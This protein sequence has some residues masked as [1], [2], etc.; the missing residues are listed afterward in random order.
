MKTLIDANICKIFN[1]N[2]PK[3][4]NFAAARLVTIPAVQP[5]PRA[6]QVLVN[7]RLD[8]LGSVP[9]CTAPVLVN[10]RSWIKLANFAFLK[11]F[12]FY[13]RSF[14]EVG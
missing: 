3:N 9:G 11:M 10:P 1:F 6:P 13:A 7:P 8:A 5:A 4:A 14:N 2:L 12:F